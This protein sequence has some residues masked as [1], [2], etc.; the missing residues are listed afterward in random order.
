MSKTGVP[1]IRMMKISRISPTM[2]ASTKE[3]R[4]THR[5][6]PTILE[7]RTTKVGQISFQTKMGNRTQG[8][9]EVK[10][11]TAGTGETETEAR[12]SHTKSSLEIM[13][14][15]EEILKG[16]MSFITRTMM[17]SSNTASS[18]SPLLSTSTS[19]PSMMTSLTRS[20]RKI[21]LKKSSKHVKTSLRSNTM[22]LNTRSL[23]TF[24]S[25]ALLQML[26][27]YSG[28]YTP[29]SLFSPE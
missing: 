2:V 15:S 21:S 19:A 7:Q 3:K 22:R 26:A 20:Q 8:H 1:T 11:A 9:T 12:K 17:H 13:P 23:L 25:M 29:W 27:P 24:I 4:R 14:P 6:R 18:R 10:E 16:T 28:T 5:S